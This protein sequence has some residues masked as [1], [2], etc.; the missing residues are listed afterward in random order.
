MSLGALDLSG[1]R[2]DARLQ[3]LDRKRVELQ[4]GKRIQWIARPTRQILV[5]L[6][7]RNVDPHD[8][9]VNKVVGDTQRTG[10]G[11]FQT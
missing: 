8:R 5:G 2:G 9:R 3:L 11:F 6:H 4:P 10:R 1:Q 7:L